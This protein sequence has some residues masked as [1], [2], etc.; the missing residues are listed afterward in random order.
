MC[1]QKL[2]FGVNVG[3]FCI[4][5]FVTKSRVAISFL[6]G[7]TEWG[8][9]KIRESAVDSDGVDR[10]ENG[11]CFVQ[12]TICSISHR[13]ASLCVVPCKKLIATRDFVITHCTEWVFSTQAGSRARG[14]F[15]AISSPFQRVIWC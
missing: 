13:K 5:T 4:S 3:L 2:G 7:A 11:T 10:G 12:S 15:G 6:H 9:P 8:S 14:S 1:S